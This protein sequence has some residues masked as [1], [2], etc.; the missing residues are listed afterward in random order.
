MRGRKASKKPYMPFG[1]PKGS[2]P[3][4]S[5]TETVNATRDMEETPPVTGF[6]SRMRLDRP[7]RKLGGRVGADMSPLSSAAKRCD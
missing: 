6:K 4:F 1:S 5:G 7:G 2:K 3:K